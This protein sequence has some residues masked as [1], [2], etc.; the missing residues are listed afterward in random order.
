MVQALFVIVSALSPIAVADDLHVDANAEFMVCPAQPTGEFSK[1][2]FP[3]V[4]GDTA[5]WQDERNGGQDIY[6]FDLGSQ[7]EWPV[8]TGGPTHNYPRISD[9]YVVWAV[10]RVNNRS[11]AVEGYDMQERKA[12]SIADQSPGSIGTFSLSVNGSKVAY[13]SLVDGLWRLRI[14]DITT[15]EERTLAN[16]PNTLPRTDIWGSIVVWME[17]R[18]GQDFHIFAFDLEANKEYTLADYSGGHLWPQVYGDMV[19][20]VDNDDDQIRGINLGTGQ[21][22]EFLEPSPLRDGVA[23]TSTAVYSCDGFGDIYGWELTTGQRF[24]VKDGWA[25]V[26]GYAAYEGT[27]IYSI[28]IGNVAYALY[29]NHVIPEPATLSLLALGGLAVMRRRRR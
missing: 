10:D 29:G 5:V 25:N 21:R 27:V 4:H 18:N 12:I 14:H 11:R 28:T 6:G 9:R 26:S 20:W 1:R 2:F 15:G 17:K 22:L 16:S 24:L 13:S 7:T 3:D 23:L 8:A 19:V